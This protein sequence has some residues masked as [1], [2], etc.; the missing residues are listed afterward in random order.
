MH[1]VT[2]LAPAQAQSAAPSSVPRHALSYY[3]DQFS[4]LYAWQT[5]GDSNYNALQV[6]LRHCHE[7]RVPIRLKLRVF[8]VHRRQFQRRARERIRS[9]GRC[10]LSIARRSMHVSPNL[11][12]AVSDFDTTHQINFNAIWDLPYGEAGVGAE[13]QWF[14][15]SESFGGWGFSGLCRWTSGFPF[16]VSAGN[17]WSTEFRTGG[18]LVLIGP[19]P[20]TGVF[21]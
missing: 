8:Q 10:C 4:S 7:R 17:G 13:R 12:R 20:K 18:V 9:R 15:E 1:S 16:T 19:K 14:D 6:S 21:H 5:R 2:R 3:Q 11:W